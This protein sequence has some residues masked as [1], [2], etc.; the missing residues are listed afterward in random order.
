[1]KS[2]SVLLFTAGLVSAVAVPVQLAER[3][4]LQALPN[5]DLPTFEDDLEKRALEYINLGAREEAAPAPA[6]GKPAEGQ[7]AEGK[8]AE[9]QPAEGQ[10]AEGKPAEGKPAEGKPAEGQPAEGQPP[11]PTQSQGGREGG[12]PA[13]S[14][15]APSPTQKPN[16]D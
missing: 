8:P 11:A 5:V 13:E 6:E 9:G 10:P 2:V 12:K 14:S 7:P 1:M 15:A 3:E 16:K 4:A